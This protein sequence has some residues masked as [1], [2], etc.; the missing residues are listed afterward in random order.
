MKFKFA[1][2]LV[3][4]FVLVCCKSEQKAVEIPVPEFLT[5]DLTAGRPFS[6]AVR[7]GNWLILSGQLGYDSETGG[8]VSGGIKAE[9]KQ[10]MENIKRTLEKYG[11]SL[12]HVVKCTRNFFPN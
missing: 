11:S 5:S 6:E 2:G 10:T 9:T 4:I 3:F 7:F 12:D 8:L 1:L